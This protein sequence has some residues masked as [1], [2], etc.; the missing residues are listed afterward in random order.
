MLRPAIGGH[1]AA[2]LVS[3]I[4]ASTEN[5]SEQARS[6]QPGKGRRDAE[7]IGQIPGPDRAQGRPYAGRA[8]DDALREIEAPR[9]ARYVGQRQG[10]RTPSTAPETPSIVCTATI[11]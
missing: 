4:I 6:S 1:W 2:G 7:E 8:A 10:T 9:P 3:G 11:M 5:K